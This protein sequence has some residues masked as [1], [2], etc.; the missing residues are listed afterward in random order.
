M[1]F[2][3][4]LSVMTWIAVFSLL[5]QNAYPTF[6]PICF[7]HGN[8]GAPLV[9]LNCFCWPAN[10]DTYFMR[11]VKFIVLILS[12]SCS[13]SKEVYYSLLKLRSP[14][15]STGYS[16]LHFINY[17]GRKSDYKLDQNNFV[18]TL[19]ISNLFFSIYSFYIHFTVI[20]QKS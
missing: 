17:Y 14:P 16:E 8:W 10:P 18:F 4:W 3:P 20:F 7:V 11:C 2:C 13:L 19:G 15:L 6:F 5:C 9:S 12:V 1:L